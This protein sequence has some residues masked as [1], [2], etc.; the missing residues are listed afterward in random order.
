MVPSFREGRARELRKLEH[1]DSHCARHW[2]GNHCRTLAPVPKETGYFRMVRRDGE[3]LRIG[4]RC[5]P[6]AQALAVESSESVR[7]P[8]VASGSTGRPRHQ[9]ARIDPEMFMYG[10]NTAG[11]RPRVAA[12]PS[13]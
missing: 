4:A 9:L 11:A 13:S 1:A 7:V 8:A 10:P 5:R 12:R 6:P 3:G 2:T